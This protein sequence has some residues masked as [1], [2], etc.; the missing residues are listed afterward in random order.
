MFLRDIESITS[1]CQSNLELD[2]SVRTLANQFGILTAM[3]QFVILPA[4]VNN[5]IRHSLAVKTHFVLS[6]LNYVSQDYV[7]VLLKS[8]H[9]E[10]IWRHAASVG[11][12]CEILIIT[13][14]GRDA[15]VSL[16]ASISNISTGGMTEE[17]KNQ[18]ILNLI[19]RLV[20]HAYEM[21]YIICKLFYLEL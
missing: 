17:T 1:L 19:S 2:L 5:K 14:F 9:P 6:M 13:R 11:A 18:E 15:D 20:R 4:R 16:A 7:S 8:S 21:S 10:L 12:A 3:L